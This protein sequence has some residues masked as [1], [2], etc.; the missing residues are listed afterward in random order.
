MIQHTGDVHAQA[1]D[2]MGCGADVRKIRA[3]RSSDAH[4]MIKP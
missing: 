4:S 2:R 3:V 1:P